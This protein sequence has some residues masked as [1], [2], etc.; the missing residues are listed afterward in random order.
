MQTSEQAAPIQ[1]EVQYV[2][3]PPLPE[4]EAASSMME[5]GPNTVHESIATKIIDSVLGSLDLE[6]SDPA[7]M[8]LETGKEA[9]SGDRAS[10]QRATKLPT[11][12][13]RCPK[14]QMKG[15]MHVSESS[16]GPAENAQ[17]VGEVH[18]STPPAMITTLIS[19]LLRDWPSSYFPYNLNFYLTSALYSISSEEINHTSDL[20]GEPCSN[21]LYSKTHHLFQNLQS[22][23]TERLIFFGNAVQY[24]LSTNALT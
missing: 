19:I 3:P 21:Q 6:G 12:K 22:L 10:R 5:D 13:R 1:P 16:R 2:P 4:E 18:P 11:G 9:T 14:W 8:D 20:D 7:I 15:K 23:S 24:G 17:K